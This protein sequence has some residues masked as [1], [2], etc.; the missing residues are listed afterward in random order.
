MCLLESILISLHSLQ[1]ALGECAELLEAN[2]EGEKLPPGKHS[3][4]GLGKLA[5]APGNSTVL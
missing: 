5:P 2:P 4:K 1:V 3:T